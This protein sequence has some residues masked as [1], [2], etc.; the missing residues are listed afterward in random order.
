M[1]AWPHPSSSALLTRSSPLV[2]HAH[3]PKP[4]AAAIPAPGPALCP[5]HRPR[6]RLGRRSCAW[7]RHF[8]PREA[9]WRAG[10]FFLRQPRLRRGRGWGRGQVGG[11]EPATSGG[12][13]RRAPA[14]RGAGA[15][16]GEPRG[17][18]W[19]TGRAVLG[20]RLGDTAGRPRPRARCRPFLL[21]SSPVR[22]P[23]GSG[24]ARG[25]RGYPAPGAVG[26]RALIVGPA[27]GLLGNKPPTQPSPAPNLR[28]PLMLSWL[29]LLVANI[30]VPIASFSPLPP[31][32]NSPRREDL[33]VIFRYYFTVKY[34][35]LV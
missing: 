6:S 1:P 31:P 15:R 29:A 4:G 22:G 33:D 8:G 25:P 27:A 30:S 19:R 3:G 16:G 5:A 24:P 26:S 11:R 2:G 9:A 10:A 21:P 12:A 13:D 18:G 32:P 14:V 34:F 35:P 7:S 20:R 17:A 28:R 23:R